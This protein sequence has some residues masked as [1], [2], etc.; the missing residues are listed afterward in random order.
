MNQLSVMTHSVFRGVQ[1]ALEPTKHLSALCVFAC[2]VFSIPQAYSSNALPSLGNASSNLISLSQEKKLGRSWLRSLRGQVPTF[3]HPIVEAY[4]SQ[5]VY[6]LAPYSNVP[7]TDFRFVVVDSKALNAFAVPG[8]I[9]GINSGL[10]LHAITEQEFASVIAHELAH[11][12]QR[13]YARRLEQQRLNT[14]LTLAGILASVV[15]AATAGSEAGVA[16]L[17]SAQAMSVENQLSFS[18]QNEEEAD[19]LG[20]ATMYQSGYDPRAM[21]VMFERMYRKTRLQGDQLPEYLSTHPLSENRISDTRNRATQF[22]RA[23]Y[24]DNIEYHICQAI[25]INHFS[26]SPAAAESYFTSVIEKGNS[27]QI[28]GAKFGLAL[29]QLSSDPQQAE[30]QLRELLKSHPNKISIQL[31]LAEALYAQGNVKDA[32]TLMEELDKRNPNNYPI[33]IYLNQLYM[34]ELQYEKAT[35]LLS[36]RVN[37]FPEKPLLWYELA[38][39]SGKAGQIVEVHQARAEYFILINRLERAVE[40]LKLAKEKSKPNTQTY[41]LI[42]QR[43][44]D[45]LTMK[46]DKPF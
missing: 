36:E 44:N 18:R 30:K 7:D 14:P 11:I 45:V 16:T 32:T 34:D 19:R 39:V 31:T 23:S 43:L 41:T 22:P 5:I 26:D 25:V 24:Q 28:E 9:I 4:F 37:Y 10:F 38:E 15:V 6:S 13:H 3:D 21:P 40:Q 17:A 35:K 20:I 42:D 12:S 29:S 1:A 2:L 27:V 8:S 46:R 33:T